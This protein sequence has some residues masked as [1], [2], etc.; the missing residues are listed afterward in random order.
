[1]TKRFVQTGSVLQRSIALRMTIVLLSLAGSTALCAADNVTDVATRAAGRISPLPTVAPKINGQEDSKAPGPEL[2]WR[3]NITDVAIGP[4]GRVIGVG[5]AGLVINVGDLVSRIVPRSLSGHRDF[6]SASSDGKGNYW[7]ADRAGNIS[8]LD[9]QGNLGEAQITAAE[10]ALFKLTRLVDGSLLG[11][12]EF[13]SVMSLPI[14]GDDWEVL[15]LPWDQ[16]LGSAFREDEGDVVPHLYG[17]CQ[18]RDGTV[19]I[20]GEY[21]LVLVRVEGIWQISYQPDSKGNLFACAASPSGEVVAVGQLGRALLLRG[22]AWSDL[23]VEIQK[24]LYAVTSA[25]IGFVA[26]GE[27]GVVLTLNPDS[28]RQPAWQKLSLSSPP[29]WLSAILTVDEGLLVVGNGGYISRLPSP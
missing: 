14:G 10:G 2:T 28:D 23:P 6:L 9:A 8:L 12:G 24:D 27:H 13:G 17:I 16:L 25:K 15:R 1:M 20:T 21:G 22:S 26:A 4:A 3:D 19:Y 18:A 29:R 5:S 11:A 7:L